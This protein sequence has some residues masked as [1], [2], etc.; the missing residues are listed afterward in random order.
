MQ[1]T[2][3]SDN[4]PGDGNVASGDVLRLAADAANLGIWHW[5]LRTDV[6]QWSDRCRAQLALPPGQPATMDHLYAVMHPEDR[7]RVREAIRLAH[8]SG[9]DYHADYRIV[10]PDGSVIWIADMGRTFF[11]EAHRPV[12]MVGIT[13]DITRLKR[14]EQDLRELNA[15]LE[16]K[17]AERTGAL[18]AERRRFK[19]TLDS[20]LDAH[21][22]AEP[23]RDDKAKVIDFRILDANPAACEWTG[24]AEQQIVNHC[25]LELYPT[26]RDTGLLPLF[27][28]TADTG[29]PTCVDNLPYPRDGGPPR[30]LD[31]RAVRTNGHVSFTWRDVTDQREAARRLVE[32]EE[33]FRLLAENSSD[34]VIRTDRSGRMLWVSPSLEAVLGWSPEEWIGR[35]GADVLGPGSEQAT[36]VR[37]HARAVSGRNVV[38]RA[39]LPAQ[40]GSWH[41]AEFHAGP[42]R[43]RAGQIEGAVSSFRLVDKE[44]EAERILEQRARTDDLTLLLNRKEVWEKLSGLT[45]RTGEDIAVLLCDIDRFKTVND[46]LGH[47]AGDEVLRAIA[48]RMRRC[49]RSSDDLAARIGGD[50]LLVILRGVR[51]LPD[52][53]AI[54]EKL[55]RCI[56]EPIVSSAGPVQVTLSI[57]VTLARPGEA[58]DSLV[59]RADDAMYKAKNSGRDRVIALDADGVPA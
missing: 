8:D 13:L 16:A 52:A 25:F 26:L 21:V 47:A 20:L 5:D 30:S 44:V 55:R 46:T 50:E 17:I 10:H 34:V 36:F 58:I 49:L 48:D 53:V 3:R 15:S 40:D 32:S 11:D 18:I 39:R 33:R 14:A 45:R 27:A 4:L 37:E 51:G 2:Q 35:T 28:A 29:E 41:W 1:A 23:V 9:A 7:D 12:S 31:I 38:A 6:Q 54:A 42:F 24:L 19:A 22:L 56:A 43:S 59:A 57:G